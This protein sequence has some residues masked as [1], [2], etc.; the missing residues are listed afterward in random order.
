MGE[1]TEVGQTKEQTVSSGSK[2]YEA[3]NWDQLWLSAHD[4]ASQ[5]HS[6]FEEEH[7]RSLS[8]IVSCWQLVTAKEGRLSFCRVWVDGNPGGV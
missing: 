1:R 4:Q 7:M 6:M 2:G 5:Q 8:L 3:M